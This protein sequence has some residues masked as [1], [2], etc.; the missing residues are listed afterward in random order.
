MAQQDTGPI[1]L[2]LQAAVYICG[3]FSS[4]TSN[5]VW[6]VVPLWLIKLGASPMMIGISLGA[7]T[8][9]PLFLSIPGGALIDRLGARR[10]IFAFGVLIVCMTPLY[11]LLP[12]IPALIVLQMVAGLSTSMGW[13]STQA[14]VG[15]RMRGNP[16][17]AG[18][19]AFVVRLGTLVGP[20]AVGLIWDHFGEWGAF[21]FMTLWTAGVLVGVA[22]LPKS[23]EEH[24]AGP[25]AFR[26]GDF[27]P[28][29]QS[30]R[31][32]IGLL[33][34]A[35]I[36]LVVMISVLRQSG[37]GI[38][39]SFYVVYLES[40]DLSGALIG[41]LTSA[42][43]VVGAFGA[44]ATGPLTRVFNPFWMLMV[45]VAL[46][47]VFIAVT[48]LISAYLL[49]LAAIVARGAA[50]GTVQPLMLSIISQAAKSG[51]QGKAV[52]LRA[53]A[54]RFAMTV[55]PVIMGAVVEVTGLKGAFLLVGAVLLVLL[56]G[57]A[58]YVR[59]SPALNA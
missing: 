59:R 9:L 34:I 36:L 26:L 11:P 41:S 44:L 32:A 57:L 7:Y 15:Q 4:G 14:L 28:R 33:T 30:Y 43:L 35:P 3:I 1:S 6:V 27:R 49:L 25:Q 39:S 52:G 48:P 38:Q 12:W 42:F 45:T 40:I 22:L 8:F 13:I 18:R 2:R 31:E 54:N 21:G 29:F 5:I 17:Y 19:L 58:L 24:R 46:S 10:V 56:A 16:T 47:I 53:T 50:L 37:Q 23:E 20:P 55:I 51:D